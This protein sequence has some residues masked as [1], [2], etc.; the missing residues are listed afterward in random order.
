VAPDPRSFPELTISF[1]RGDSADAYCA[2]YADMLHEKFTAPHPR[3]EG[4]GVYEAGASI[5]V[6]PESYE[7]WFAAVSYTRR[8]VRRAL[9]D[10]YSHAEIDRNDYLDDI[11]AINTSMDE[12]QGR[13]MGESYTERPKPYS[14]L[15]AY[16]CMRHRIATFGV[17]HDRTLVAY[18]WVYQVG[19]MCL[20]STILGH[21]E[22]LENGIMYLLIAE[23]LR[24]LI[25]ESGTR[26]AMYNMHYSGTAGLRFFKERMG[27]RPYRVKWLLDNAAPAQPSAG[28]AR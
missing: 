10:G 21:G 5:L 4:F 25:E 20:F 22:H 8:K 19:E 13:P 14:A 7:A 3:L 17:L 12:R 15:P 28:A 18:T 9:R 2:R 24:R 23:S 11:F 6:L 16:G 1:S 27:F 26:Y